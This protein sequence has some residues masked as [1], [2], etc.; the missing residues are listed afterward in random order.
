MFKEIRPNKVLVIHPT[1]L[2][3]ASRIYIYIYIYTI[4]IHYICIHVDKAPGAGLLS[5][6][7]LDT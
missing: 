3:A 2:S 5:E 7:V 1:R 6:M 4:C